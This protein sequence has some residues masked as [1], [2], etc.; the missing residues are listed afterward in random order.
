MTFGR[1]GIL[2]PG[3]LKTPHLRSFLE[4]D[5]SKVVPLWRLGQKGYDCLAGWGERGTSERVR[6]FCS[7]EGIPYLSLEDGFFRSY[8][9]GRT[10][11]P[12]AS[13]RIDPFGTYYAPGNNAIHERLRNPGTITQTEI[14]RARR[15]IAQIR[16]EKLSK[17]NN[18]AI[19][20]RAQSLMSAL[21]ERFILIADQVSGDAALEHAH[22]DEFISVVVSAHTEAKAKGLPIVIRLHPEILSGERQGIILEEIKKG[23]FQFFGPQGVVWS[24]FSAPVNPYELFERTEALYVH[25]SQLGFD[26]LI[27]GVPVR[28]KGRPFYAGLG[29]TTDSSEKLR[30]PL[31]H[32]EVTLEQLFVASCLHATRYVDPSDGSPI[33][34]EQ[35]LDHIK[36]ERDAREAHAGNR[37]E[38]IGFSP[39]KKSFMPDFMGKRKR[40]ID[41]TRASRNRSAE[42]RIVWGLSNVSAQ[43]R[44]EDGFLRSM[45]LG[46]TLVRPL[47]LVFD[48]IGIHYDASKPSRLEIILQEHDFT[49]WEIDRARTLR[50]SIVANGLTKYNLPN[51][52]HIELPTHK[53]T[54]LVIGQVEDDASI[55]SNLSS[56]RSN[57]E[58]IRAARRLNPN[59]FLAY[60]P[61]PDVAAGLRRGAVERKQLQELVDLVLDRHSITP[62][63]DIFDEIHTIS[64]TSGFEAII[65]GERPVVWGT[66]FY[67]GWGL[68][69]NKSGIE[70]P[71]R[72]RRL[73]VD[74]LIAATLILYPRYVHPR[75]RRLCRA[76][77][78]VHALQ[79]AREPRANLMDT[80]SRQLMSFFA[81]RRH[82][83]R[84]SKDY[85]LEQSSD[86]DFKIGT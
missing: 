67:S 26:A 57:L 47:S 49:S 86:D 20:L 45:G 60:K 77:S 71:R 66:P 65:R 75:S 23:T 46:A 44:V 27:A 58:L 79:Q 41:F 2:S 53:K 6:T 51:A 69:D 30:K 74:Q 37:S 4:A 81:R 25:S 39:W 78:I 61:H 82:H 68:D 18:G 48:D 10:G 13:M 36:A 64:S 3:I 1:I 9:V 63:Y 34:L 32:H 59:A 85:V 17:Y 15:C 54:I 33:E 40:D 8:N 19:G 50:Q 56:I 21:P 35:A 28:T 42:H 62:L 14:E 31:Y 70:L 84:E 76:E 7:K 80:L 72:T 12:S 11:E 5:G 52:D 24:T 16:S 29:L 83:D 43:W 22:R 38:L 73:S 55:L